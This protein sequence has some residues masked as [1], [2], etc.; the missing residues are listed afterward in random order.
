MFLRREFGTENG[1]GIEHEG[2]RYAVWFLEDGIH[3]ARGNSVLSGYDRTTVAW[4]QASARILELLNAGTYLPQ[5][6]W[7]RRRSTFSSMIG[8]AQEYHTF[9]DAYAKSR[10]H[11]AL[12]AFGV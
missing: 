9:L 10:T 5:Q 8:P 6:N 2:R 12:V 11:L 7:S 3:L 1:R 4:E